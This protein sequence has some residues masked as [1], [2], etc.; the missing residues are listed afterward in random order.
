MNDPN[1]HTHSQP[2]HEVCTTVKRHTYKIESLKNRTL[3]DQILAH[4]F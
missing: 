1:T 3:W 4:L 2:G